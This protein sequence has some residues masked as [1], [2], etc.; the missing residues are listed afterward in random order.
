[1]DASLVCRYQCAFET[2]AAA[3]HSREDAVRIMRKSVKL[4]HEARRRFWEGG[5]AADREK[6]AVKIALSMGPFGATLSPAQEFDGLY[7]PPYGPK[8]Y[9]TDSEDRNMNA[10]P[11]TV[12]GQRLAAESIEKLAEFHF[13]RLQVFADD[14]ET[15][16]MIDLVAFETVPLSREIKAIR[17]AVG[18]LQRELAGRGTETKRWW[19]STVW[20]DGRC[21]E[22]RRPGGDR[23]SPREVVHALLDE[24]GAGTFQGTPRPW[25]IGINC[26]S[27][28]H[29]APLLI[30]FTNAT[31]SFSSSASQAD[32]LACGL[33]E[34]RRYVRVGDGWA[35]RYWEFVKTAVEDGS[36]WSGVVVGGCCRTGPAEIEALA[37]RVRDKVSTSSDLK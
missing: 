11:D 6:R 30:E 35:L 32:G 23:V 29:L 27:L 2:F 33:S 17:R 15:W 9:T 19:V 28:D 10:F 36:V 26:T 14:A 21:P 4:A 31:C 18:K 20:P 1:M 16:E 25:G 37:D 13:G 34:W 5:Q 24:D 12:E 8:G 7:P 3:G 22:E